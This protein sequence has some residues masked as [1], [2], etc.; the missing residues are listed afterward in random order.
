[1]VSPCFRARRS[2]VARLVEMPVPDAPGKLLI[3]TSY[4]A[5]PKM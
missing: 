5:V 2:A 3:G 4:P 1:M